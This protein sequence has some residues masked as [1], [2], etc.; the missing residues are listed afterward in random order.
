MQKEN[1]APAIT[2]TSAYPTAEQIMNR[3][4]A[5]ANDSY[6]QGRGRILTDTAPFSIEY[7]NGA[8]EELQDKLANNA[9]ITLIKDNVILGPLT[10]VSGQ[11]ATQIFIGYD[12]YFD[13]TAMQSLPVLPSD[14]RAP[15]KLWERQVGSN[16]PFREMTQPQEGLPSYWQSPWLGLWEYRQ[17]RIY[18]TGSTITEEVRVRYESRL[19]TLTDADDFANTEIQILSSV[20]ALAVLVV[21]HYALARGAP[22]AANMAADAE[23]QM[24]YIV[25]RYTRRAQSVPYHRKPY[26]TSND[27]P[28]N[29]GMNGLF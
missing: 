28:G 3:A 26:Q 17:D 14:L 18:F 25:R 10:P 16:L 13:G 24:R 20:N 12:G 2:P 7:L 5:Y 4:R 21:Y 23:K 22:A 9:V 27:W 8:L 1:M 19:L 29:R 15:Q 6:R 11:P